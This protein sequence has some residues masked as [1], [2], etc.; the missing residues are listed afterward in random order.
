MLLIRH[1]VYECLPGNYAGGVQK[2]VY[3]LASAQRRAGADVEVWTPNRARAGT[4]E[5]HGG[6]PI[7]YF[8]PEAAFGLARSV[9]LEQAMAGLP[10]GSVLHAHNT[11]HPLNLQ[12]GRAARHGRH[13][14]FY[15]PHG[16]LDPVLF[17]GWNFQALKKRIYIAACER[18]NLDRASGVFALTPLERQQLLSLGVSSPIGIVPNGIHPVAVADA[19]AGLDFRRRHGIPAGAP[20][21]LF[22]GRIVP[23]KR[24]DDIIGALARLRDVFPD[25]HFAI[26]GNPAQHP[27]YHA[28]LLRDIEAHGLG[29]RVRWLGFL[30]EKTKPEAYAASQL[31][32]HASESEGMALAILEAMSAGLPVVVTQGCYMS[33]AA[34]AGALCE[35]E[36]GPVALA[37]A[38]RSVLS[39]S[40][41]LGQRGQEY[42]H[43]IHQWDALAQRT[44]QL[45]G[46]S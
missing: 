43:L 34:A 32:V 33:E 18:P 6:L 22:I 38:L 41:D 25:L 29:G 45:Y 11:F 30:D 35:C 36:Q 14:A 5:V 10:A 7:R 17:R 23:K 42:V 3:E 1:V 24:L 44:L 4:T 9:D 19:A 16:A 46:G 37:A 26:A 13:R 20:L 40:D 21:M 2:M 27:A 15:H 39:A 12:V 31:F 8:K 28:G